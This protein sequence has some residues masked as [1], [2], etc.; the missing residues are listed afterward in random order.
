MVCG[1][2]RVKVVVAGPPVVTKSLP[3]KRICFRGRFLAPCVNLGRFAGSG[4][5]LCA[6]PSHSPPRGRRRVFFFIVRPVRDDPRRVALERAPEYFRQGGLPQAPCFGGCLPCVLV[7]WPPVPRQAR[8]FL[9]IPRSR[10]YCPASV[11]FV[12]SSRPPPCVAFPFALH[13][14]RQTPQTL[15]A[16]LLSPLGEP[17]DGRARGLQPARQCNT[18]W[19]RP[20]LPDGRGYGPGKPARG[21]RCPEVTP[22]AS[23]DGPVAYRCGAGSP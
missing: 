19:C 11:F 5:R 4:E 14:A 20:V 6:R 23:L 1:V 15:R 17:N 13:V 2:E 12:S 10:A 16:S 7:R 8:F 21:A 18:C 9:G 22:Q 3:R